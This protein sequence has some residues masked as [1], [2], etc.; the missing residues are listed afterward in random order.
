MMCVPGVVRGIFAFRDDSGNDFGFVTPSGNDQSTI[1]LMFTDGNEVRYTKL[2]HID[3]CLSAPGGDPS[4]NP[5]S[6][7]AWLL[8]GEERQ[9]LFIR[10]KSLQDAI[11]RFE[12]KGAK[13]Q[14]W[15]VVRYYF[16]SF[17]DTTSLL[18]GQKMSVAHPFELEEKEAGSLVESGFKITTAACPNISVVAL[19]TLYTGSSKVHRKVIVLYPHEPDPIHVSTKSFGDDN[20]KEESL[21]AEYFWMQR[22]PSSLPYLSRFK[23]VHRGVGNE[24]DLEKGKHA[25]ISRY[26]NQ[27]NLTNYL[28][29]SGQ[30]ADPKARLCLALQIA[31]AISSLHSI[32]LIHGDLKTTNILIQENE[33][34]PE[35][36]L[37]D[38]TLMAVIGCHLARPL[39]T[40][41]SPEAAF[42]TTDLQK[43]GWELSQAN[44]PLVLAASAVDCWAF[45]VLLCDLFR[46]NL[47]HVSSFSYERGREKILATR[48][49][50]VDSLAKP[51]E[52]LMD[53]LIRSLLDEDPSK[54]LSMPE[55]ILNIKRLLESSYDQKSSPL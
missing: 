3:V 21:N 20:E 50:L 16:G 25:L 45:G 49:D 29:R 17:F 51:G 26:F 31:E 12:N 30:E 36:A 42:E 55:V 41:P 14:I 4:E 7:N 24:I 33:T 44:P 48:K 32:N 53:D 2:R 11:C 46:K 37:C 47:I 13:G 40:F 1:T 8:I 15:I 38:F 54:R 22:L 18:M 10:K 34:G 5:F 6:I 28:S 27:G 35:I 23:Q 19:K 39:G 9:R 43:F 52:N